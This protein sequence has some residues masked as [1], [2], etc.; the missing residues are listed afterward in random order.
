MN[1]VLQF[2][3][4]PRASA[5]RG[6][7]NAAANAA[8]P[9]PRPATDAPKILCVDDD[10]DILNCM[11]RRLQRQYAVR[12]A[13][14][15]KA[16][17]EI[18]RNEG[19][20]EVIITDCRMPGM[21]GAELLAEMRGLAPETTR[22]MLT[23]ATDLEAALEAIN[24][25]DVFRF[26]AKPTPGEQLDRIV[27]A[28][29]QQ[30]RLQ[31]S[32]R[33][34]LTRTVRGCLAAFADLLA[35]C[36]PE[37]FGRA[38]RMR[39]LA[40]RI[41]LRLR[42]DCLWELEAAALFAHVG[43]LGDSARDTGAERPMT[44]ETTDRRTELAAVARRFIA[45]I[46]HFEPVSRILAGLGDCG[47]GAPRPAV[48]TRDP[49]PLPS[50]ILA[51]VADF[52]ALSADVSPIEAIE[53]LRRSGVHEPTLVDALRDAVSIDSAG[54]QAEESASMDYGV[55]EDAEPLLNTPRGEALVELLLARAESRSAALGR[56]DDR[57]REEPS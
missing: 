41:A 17:L 33:I 27:A 46:P 21:T 15:A 30:H 34:L 10:E 16:A 6:P 8:A 13:C 42:A 43:M 48:A 25:G 23:G 2:L 3:N 57:R 44:D 53:R 35:V 45:G 18:V 22:V 39:T 9:G 11:R 37:V 24:S 14:A 7:S 20:F 1:S 51:A 12:T 47:E 54:A 52:A 4:A 40:T 49:V 26:L 19:P 50:R 28:A 55:P 38:L 5:S 29:V 56:A 32:Q 36:E 31:A